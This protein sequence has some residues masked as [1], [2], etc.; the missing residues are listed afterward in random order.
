MTESPISTWSVEW[1][2]SVVG[3]GI[4]VHLLAAYLKPRIDRIGARTSRAWAA[5]NEERARARLARID[6]LRRKEARRL[7][8]AFEGLRCYMRSIKYFLFAIAYCFVGFLAIMMHALPVASVSGI[9]ALLSIL[10]S[11][12]SERNARRIHQAELTE[13]LE[14]KDDEIPASQQQRDS[15]A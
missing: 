14:S 8:A 3:V 5:R 9:M 6:D 12:S 15:R 1:W 4:A 7:V 11:I 2:A 10:L 13:A